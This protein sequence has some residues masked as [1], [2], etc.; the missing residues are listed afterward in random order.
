MMQ[1]PQRIPVVINAAVAWLQAHRAINS[2][3]VIGY[4]LFILLAH[5]AFVQHSIW[6]MNALTLPVYNGVVAGIAG[7]FGV[8]F[9]LLMLSFFRINTPE[10]PRKLFYL[11]AILLL[12][13]VHHIFL[14]E[15]NIEVIHAM[16]FAVLGF[17]LFPFTQRFGAAIAMGIPIMMLDEWYQYRVL[18]P[19]YVQ[20]FDFNDILMDMLGCALLLC[21]MWIVGVQTKPAPQPIYRRPEI[22]LMA[23][24]S[25]AIVTAILSCTIAFFPE[26]ACPNTWLV[27]NKLPNP[28]IFWQ[29]HPFTGRIY[30]A[31]P[32]M[33][34]MA[35]ILGISLFFLGM[36]RK[37]IED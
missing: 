15:M 21:G 9:V 13:V 29:V 25:V 3:L 18:Y 12:L 6:V 8:L 4:A 11:I 26:N 31:I 1:N 34:G 30:H 37:A 20:Y 36:G 16:Q 22:I 28:L 24:L 7:V 33:E 10:R 27:L 35:V 23:A 5:N 19:D 14:F 17:L 32:P 2:A